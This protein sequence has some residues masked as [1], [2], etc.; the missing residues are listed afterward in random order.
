MNIRHFLKKQR[1]SAQ[2]LVE[3]ALILVL[4]AVVVIVVLL[5]LGPAVGNT[6]ST[7]MTY[8]NSDQGSGPCVLSHGDFGSATVPQ[9]VL[10]GNNNHTSGGVWRWTGANLRHQPTGRVVYN[11]S[12]MHGTT[13]TGDCSPLG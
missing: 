10:D 6:F 2:G 8:L 1:E 5:Q 9:T 4:V 7:L 3:Y 11:V 12:W 13:A